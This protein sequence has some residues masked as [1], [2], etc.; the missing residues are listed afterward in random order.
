MNQDY[1]GDATQLK[2]LVRACV[3][4][5]TMQHL[6]LCWAHLEQC[7]CEDGVLTKCAIPAELGVLELYLRDWDVTEIAPHGFRDATYMRWL[8]LSHNHL[9]ALSPAAFRGAQNLGYLDLSHNNISA[10]ESGGVLRKLETL[11]LRGN[12]IAALSSSALSGRL[13]TLFLDDNGM[14][15]VEAGAFGA[16]PHLEHVWMGGNVLNCSSVEALLPRGVLCIE[17]RCGV[18]DL[19]WIGD[20]FCN[21]VEDPEYDTAQCAFDGGDC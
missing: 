5:P 17:E 7:D 21:S 12:R 3:I 6:E 16:I 13:R 11:A 10:V 8:D 19:G 14:R 18:D 4:C 1:G 9:S 15:V 20:A 2:D